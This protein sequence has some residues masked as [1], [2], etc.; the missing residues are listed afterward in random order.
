MAS[1]IHRKRD[2][3]LNQSCYLFLPKKK[4]KAIG[5]TDHH[6]LSP[7][8]FL[9]QSH[10]ISWFLFKKKRASVVAADCA[11][12]EKSLFRSCSPH[13]PCPAQFEAHRRCSEPSAGRG[14]QSSGR[15]EFPHGTAQVTEAG[16]GFLVSGESIWGFL[17]SL[18]S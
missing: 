14:A 13:P 11:F 1:T 5:F 6:R 12:C 18:K 15:A 16:S 17:C 10:V 8:W 3:T 9:S 4:N 7:S 2:N